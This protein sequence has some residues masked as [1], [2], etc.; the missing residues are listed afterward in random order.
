MGSIGILPTTGNGL[1]AAADGIEAR[2]VDEPVSA[3]TRPTSHCK[4]H[5]HRYFLGSTLLRGWIL[6]ELLPFSFLMCLA[7]ILILQ[8]LFECKAALVT[9]IWQKWGHRRSVAWFQRHLRNI[10]EESNHHID[11]HT[12]SV[13]RYLR[14][15]K[16][17]NE[18]QPAARI[19]AAELLTLRAQIRDNSWLPTP[20]G[21]R[22]MDEAFERERHG[23][24]ILPM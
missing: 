23:R 8:A 21:F 18:V 4:S 22:M 10:S 13:E 20:R 16:D 2:I 17:E 11:V 1:A 9:L 24:P 15:V 7:A 6:S 5:F 3:S 12:T 19:T 14:K